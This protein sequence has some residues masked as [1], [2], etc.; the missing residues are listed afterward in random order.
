MTWL[1]TEQGLP[2]W[3]L[4]LVGVA[5]LMAPFYRYVTTGWKAKRKDILDGLSDDACQAY[6]EMFSPGDGP[7]TIDSAKEA[8]QDLYSRWYGRQYFAIPG[9]LLFLAGGISVAAIVFTG[10]DVFGYQRNPFFN[11]PSPAIAALA[12]AYLW[13]VNDHTSRARRLDFSP[14][15]VQWA[16]LRIVIAIP[17]GYAF[18]ALVAK[19]LAPFI[20]FAIGAFPLS[21]LLSMLR[22]VS[23]K[24]LD[25]VPSAAE[26]QDDIIKLQGVN[27]AIL[28]RLKNED[29]STV[30]QIA[31]CD[32]VRLVMR[33]NLTF[34][35]VTDCMNQALAWTYLETKL[36]A[37]RS[38]S[39]RGA[40]EIRNFVDAYDQVDG[41]T[42]EEHEL[43]VKALP[44]LAATAQQ[45]EE[46]LMLTLREIAGDPY[47]VFLTRVWATTG[48]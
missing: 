26:S 14:A 5:T 32:P 29:I 4:W 30:T 20:A 15:D 11:L 18:S 48:A 33:S 47:T 44:R 46:T 21:E 8:F 19:P 40:T 42:E 24:K 45:D 16:V 25:I 41:F 27:K 31:Y 10:F 9:V 34:T 1:F 6:F 37:L 36:A 13:A 2:F 28:E 17:M 35:F 12:G 43:A 7:Q 39:L 23:E 22:V 3:G 38:L